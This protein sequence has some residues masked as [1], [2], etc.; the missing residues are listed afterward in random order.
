MLFYGFLLIL[1]ATQGDAMRRDSTRCGETQRD[2]VRCGATLRASND[3][4]L[5]DLLLTEIMTVIKTGCDFARLKIKTSRVAVKR[6][7]VE[8]FKT[9]YEPPHRA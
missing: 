2:A 3:R 6:K 1:L 9:R 8:I 5:D 4:S 7:R